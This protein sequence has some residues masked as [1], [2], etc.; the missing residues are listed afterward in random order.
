MTM[1]KALH[2]ETMLTD[3]MYQEKKRGKGLASIEDNVDASIWPL[4]D[5]IEKH[6]DR[7]IIAIRNDTDNTMDNRMTITRTGKEEETLSEKRNLS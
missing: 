7:L 1:H 4:E 2:P 6:E 3:Y 5:Y